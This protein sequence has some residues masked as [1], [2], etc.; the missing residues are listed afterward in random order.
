M[1]TGGGKKENEIHYAP[2]WDHGFDVSFSTESKEPTW[3]PM[4]TPPQ[5]AEDVKPTL[6]EGSPFGTYYWKG[7]GQ[8]ATENLQGDVSRII[9]DRVIPFIKKSVASKQPFLTVSWFHAPH[10]PV[11][12]G[13]KY[14][15][16]YSHLSEGQQEY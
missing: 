7:P 9:M 13:E 16:R 15:S 12:T 2:P 14:K 3:N 11:L 10:L 4:I 1:R 6:I 8:R 5:S